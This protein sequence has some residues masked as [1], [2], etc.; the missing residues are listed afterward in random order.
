MVYSIPQWQS[1]PI[2]IAS[3]V[4]R[5]NLVLNVVVLRLQAPDYHSY[6][7]S[8]YFSDRLAT[9]FF[10]L[11]DRRARAAVSIFRTLERLA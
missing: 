1:Q 10:V 4:T 3:I 5:Y 9:R 11:A 7:Q 2:P 8:K 6:S